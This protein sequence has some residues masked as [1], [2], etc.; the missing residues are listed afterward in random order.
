MLRTMVKMSGKGDEVVAEYDTETITPERLAEIEAEFDAM[1]A[2]GF[3]AADV[4]DKKN[5]FIKK[6]DPEADILMI[7]Q[8]QGG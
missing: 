2:K 1:T 6:F 4:T 8:V 7:P 5:E 3:F